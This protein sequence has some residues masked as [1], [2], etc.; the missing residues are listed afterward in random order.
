MKKLTMTNKCTSSAGRFDGHGSEPEQY[1]RHRPM[2]HIQDYSG[3][4]WMLPSGNYSLR[5]APAAARAT[6]KQTTFNKYT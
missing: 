4:H 3:S 1:R 5:I 6:G 2:Q